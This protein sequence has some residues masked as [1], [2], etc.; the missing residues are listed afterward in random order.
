MLLS[1]WCVHHLSIVFWL[2]F[3]CLV[4]EVDHSLLYGC[5]KENLIINGPRTEPTLLPQPRSEPPSAILPEDGFMRPFVSV[6][7]HH[8]NGVCTS[9]VGAI[10]S[11]Q[12]QI[13]PKIL[14]NTVWTGSETI[15]TP[16]PIHVQ[17][18]ISILIS[19]G[20]VWPE[21]CRIYLHW[22]F[23]EQHEY[24]KIYL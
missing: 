21:W 17:N 16:F 13:V 5:C 23:E 3:M 10:T 7:S 9:K 19:V 4:P 18:F 1:T 14:L 12:H 6:G 20:F 15:E 22:N 11:H 2:V 8:H 24:E